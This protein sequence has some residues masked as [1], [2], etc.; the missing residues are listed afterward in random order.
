MNILISYTLYQP[1]IYPHPVYNHNEHS[2][3]IKKY[4]D[5]L[6][7]NKS[8]SLIIFP[9]TI[10]PIPYNTQ[11]E[12]Y[13]IFN[14]HTSDKNLLLAVSLLKL[15]KNI[16]IAWYFFLTMLKFIIEKISPISESIHLGIILF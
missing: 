16:L 11:H 10:F 15:K 1:N 3:I 4:I 7:Q 6:E 9:E 13:K 12:L 5:V 2:K 8:S 14:N